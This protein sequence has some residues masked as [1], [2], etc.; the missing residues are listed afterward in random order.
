MSEWF[1]RLPGFESR[2][3]RFDRAIGEGPRARMF[4][5]YQLALRRSVA[6][7]VLRPEFSGDRYQR[8]LFLEAARAAAGLIHPNVIPIVNVLDEPPLAVVAAE[9]VPYPSLAALMAESRPLPFQ[10]ICQLA[11]HA[12]DVLRAL[13]AGDRAHG[14]LCPENVFADDDGRYRLS[15][16][17]HSP[18]PALQ[19][20]SAWRGRSEYVAPEVRLGGRAAPRSDLYALGMLLR[21]AATGQKPSNADTVEDAPAAFGKMLRWFCDPNPSRRP[22]STDEAR[23]VVEHLRQQAKAAG[24]A[25]AIAARADLPPP[26]RRRYH[27]LAADAA[28][29]VKPAYHPDFTNTPALE[30]RLRDIGENGVFVATARPRTIGELV[31]LEFDLERACRVHALGVVRWIARPPAETG[32]GVQFVEVAYPARESL[33]RYIDGR[34]PAEAERALT[35][36]PEHRAMLRVMTEHW[37]RPAAAEAEW[38]ADAGLAPEKLDK[39]IEDFVRLGLVK[40]DEKRQLEA[41]Y[42]ASRSLLQTLVR[43]AAET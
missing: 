39:V 37:N 33:T 15:D 31:S 17:H 9:L 5:G 29:Q 28:I 1:E 2:G 26:N 34:M 11:L 18:I 43:L 41:L 12:L 42:P 8:S 40:Q 22:A 19:P 36:T 4:E 32:M 10:E 3:F 35:A 38:A 6:L 25:W 13:H 23:E 24:G 14:N 30:L 7:K 27:R 20:G 21:H 16:F